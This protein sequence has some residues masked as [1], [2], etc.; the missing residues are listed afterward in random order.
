MAVLSA[1]KVSPVETAGSSEFAITLF[2]P[3]QVLLHHQPLPHLRS[4]KTLWLLALLTLRYG[5]PVE[6]EWLAGTLWPEVGQTQSFASLRAVL[7]ELRGAL[8]SQGVRLQTPSRHTIAL[9]LS[10]A[11]VDVLTFDAAI[12]SGESAALQKAVALYQGILLEGCTEEWVAQYRAQREQDC[13]RALQRLADIALKEGDHATATM[14]WRRAVILDV[15]W[16]VA[17]RG[18][19]ESLARGGDINAALYGYREFVVTIQSSDPRASPDKETTALYHQLRAQA[20]QKASRTPK[21][22]DISV[23][24]IVKGSLPHLLTE[25]VGR[26]DERL[27]VAA[28]LR[29]FRLV[30]L[31]GPGGIGKTRLANAVAGDMQGEYPDGVWFVALDALSEPDLVPQAVARVLGVHEETRQPLSETLAAF[32]KNRRLLLVLDNCEHLLDASAELMDQ[33]LRQSAGLRVLAT[34]REMLG[35]TGEVAWAVPPLAVPDP[36]HLPEGRSTIVRVL[37]GYEGVELFVERA[38]A[39]EKTFALTSANARAIANICHRLQGVPLAL[40]LAAVRVKSMTVEQIAE[41]LGEHLAGQ[42]G[43]LS[44]GSRTVPSRQQTLRGTLD[45][46]YILLNRSERL[47]LHRLSVF[48]GGWTLPAAEQVCAGKGSEASIVPEQVLDLLTSLVDKSLVGFATDLSKTSGRYYLLEMVRQYASEKLEAS[49]E[50]AVIKERHTAWFLSFAESTEPYLRGSEPETYLRRLETDYD[51]FQAALAWSATESQEPESGVRLAGALWWFWKIRAR[52]TEGRQYLSSA[53][54]RQDP[55]G[56]T[57][58]RA[59]ALDAAGALALNQGD[60]AASQSLHEQSLVLYRKRQNRKGIASVLN[61]LGILAS[62]Q[63]NHAASR[64]FYEESLGISRELDDIPGISKALSNLGNVTR[65]QGDYASAQ[66]FQEECL[67]IRRRRGDKQGI[68]HCLANLGNLVRLQGHHATARVLLEESLS[69]CRE[70]G[71]K[72]GI[73]YALSHLGSAA[74][75]IGDL[76][77]ARLLFEESLE[78]RR[79]M[80][81][82]RS[83]GWSLTNL[84]VVAFYE[85]KIGASQS[86]FEEGLSIF[87][88]LNDNGGIAWCL[89]RLGDV[90]Y[91]CTEHIQAQDYFQESLRLFRILGDKEG[92]A[93]NLRDLAAVFAAQQEEQKSA[94]LWGAAEALREKIGAP[95]PPVEQILYDHQVAHILGQDAFAADWKEGCTWTWEQAT[96]YALGE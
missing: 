26:E 14:Y 78:I 71:D 36:E 12:A 56:E 45:W 55:Q 1:S 85:G 24:S 29:R 74:T 33:L 76:A 16:E 25:L 4:R 49:G 40:E 35:V 6:R 83:T 88:E 15:R 58:A 73:A 75:T 3:M 68:G 94:R 64:V 21:A 67:K 63:G 84:G 31:T 52:F 8:G 53:M 96:A 34:S 61:N 38:Q 81:Q 2:G 66:A 69:V 18:L 10:D 70:V 7:S 57:V 89:N 54:E 48:A 9:D 91:R 92:I 20:Q 39:V 17:R 82:K 11:S 59:K 79:E 47:L 65:L 80:G 95:L 28:R 44:S 93:E 23:A 13:L 27:E 42:L 87:R 51:N 37:A 22:T 62:H 32:V 43:L 90:A 86:L 60:F 5:R 77:T 41:R 30:T 46:S 50:L 72:Q 19:M